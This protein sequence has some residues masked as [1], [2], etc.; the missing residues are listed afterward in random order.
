MISNRNTVKASRFLGV[1]NT[2]DPAD[3]TPAE[4]GAQWLA[5]ASNLDITNSAKLQRRPGYTKVAGHPGATAAYATENEQALYE[6]SGGTLYRVDSLA[7]LLRTPLAAGI[8]DG[9]LH[10]AE[11]GHMTFFS[12]GSSGIIIGDDVLPFGIPA[13]EAPG[14][15]A[16]GG[17]L[18][19]GQYLAA[20][21]FEHSSGRQGGTAGIASIELPEGGGIRFQ[22]P[23]APGCTTHLYVSRANGSELFHLSE[24]SPGE[25]W[26]SGPD[27]A[28]MPL[29]EAQIGGYPPPDDADCIAFHESRIWVSQHVAASNTSFIYPSKPF[30]YHLFALDEYIPVPGRVLAMRSVGS[31]Q[32]RGLLIGTDEAIHFYADGMLT[33]VAEFGVVPGQPVAL[34]EGVAYLWTQE[35]ICSAMPLRK[36]TQAHYS[37][38]PGSRACIGIRRFG[39]MDTLVVCTDHSGTSVNPRGLT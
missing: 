19:P 20:C 36:L 3:L 24:V 6:V 27:P 32:G 9:E 31:D 33:R 2:D 8:S 5:D 35:G 30:W 39:G 21:V 22:A 37:A 38:A 25:F 18:P 34:H 14:T 11:A 15:M 28:P 1:N 26:W 29:D 7:P 16:A 10:W 17:T 23:H 12:G 13:A 4:D